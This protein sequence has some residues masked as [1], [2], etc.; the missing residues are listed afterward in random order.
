MFGSRR[1]APATDNQP[2]QSR[3][4]VF[5]SRRAAPATDNQPE[6]SRKRVFRICAVTIAVLTSCQPEVASPTAAR[7]VL[8]EVMTDNDAAWIDEAGEVGDYIEIANLSDR[9]VELGDYALQ[10]ESGQ[11]FPLPH[12]QLA[13]GGFVVV[14]A[15]DDEDQG[16]LHAPWKLSS[17]GERL[18]LI[19]QASGEVLDHVDVPALG[20]N[21]TFSRFP[22]G[23][24]EFRVCRYASPERDNGESCSPPAPL[25]LP[26]DSSWA[27]YD[28]PE[29]WPRSQGS[30]L[31]SELALHP[32]RFIEVLNVGSEPIALADYSLRLAT[33]GPGMPWPTST[34]GAELVWP[35][36]E[37]LAPGARVVVSVSL[38][39]AS[40]IES[41]PAFE[42]VAT[43]FAADGSVADRVDFMRWPEGAVLSRWPET[44]S[45]F[46]FCATPSPGQANDTACD[47]LPSR[48][49]GDRLRHLYTPGD[50]AALAEGETNLGL[51]GVK[52]IVDTA[53]GDAVHLLSTRA[54][55]LHYTFIRE[56]IDHLARL[57]RCDA[58]QNQLFYDG[59][60]DFSD[61]EYAQ[62][63]SRRYLL[64]TLDRYSGSDL[65][66]FDFAL[67]DQIIAPQMKHA[68]FTA[69]KNLDAEPADAW[70]MHPVEPRQVVELRKVE[71]EVP[72]VGENAPFRNLKYQ[73]LTE[74]VAFGTL[75]YLPA[76]ELETA[77]L[78]QDVIVVTD[79]VPNDLPFVSG[80]ITEA[81]QTPLAHVNVLSQ[82]RGT[83]NMAL[84]QART[85]ERIARLIDEL[86]RLEVSSA[87]FTLRK[88][89]AE[90]VDA[91]LQMRAPAGPRVAPRLDA[92][93]RGMVDLATRGLADLPAIGAKAA[94]LAELGHVIA[95]GANCYGPI[96]V[97]DRSF[98]IPV[99]YYLEH[100]ERSGAR[101]ELEAVMQD[102]EFRVDLRARDA[103]LAQVRQKILDAPVD[104]DLMRELEAAILQRWG[105][106]RLRFR[107]SSNTEDLSGFNGA[108]LYESIPA[109]IGDSERPI[110]GA[111]RQVWA[112]LWLTR[113]YDER[114]Y[115]RI[116]Q[117]QVAMGVLVHPSFKSERA[118][119]IAVSRDVLDPTRADIHYLNAQ[120]GEAS[121]ANPAPGVTTEQLIHHWRAV[122]S[123]PVIEY[124]AKSS[125]T[126]GQDVLTLN[127]V[128]K[129]SCR[130]AAVHNYFQAKL[131]P[132]YQN[133]WF[134]M[135]VEIKLV[136]PSREVVFKQARPY[137][138]GRTMRPADCREF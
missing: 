89:S 111:L 34:D 27:K 101:A 12:G 8:N 124:Q 85:D 77:S 48:D 36:P 54:W 31:I 104:A 75:R 43:L 120:Q 39:A 95:T 61:R 9:A 37:L 97:P 38:D 22:S 96:P 86:V 72:V 82:N 128:L 53:M 6:Q 29:G 91:F 81:F 14:F 65:R 126:R 110:D 35:E 136:G 135:D 133:R 131:D 3:K 47:P 83:P 44:S 52:V 118:N 79:A 76:V 90:E 18:Q 134:A 40:A 24:G 66:T 109:E 117:S 71:G 15:D 100:F 46:R 64:A 105:R 62:V 16:I 116:D 63:E 58:A 138:F 60:A 94:Q 87:G 122:P 108:G 13:A 30:L 11:L 125:L 10:P 119:V 21:E 98:A 33:T 130:L 67:G 50:Y 84:R 107:S 123:A 88:A 114:E 80:L 137:T 42:G 26:D 32:A 49:V 93:V 132:Q 19:A 45:R 112:S 1:A 115:G 59:W 4:R 41:D 5:G 25:E 17:K 70:S 20:V 69:M 51:Q 127:D 106:V 74:G 68:F 92:S 57:D 113:A 129:I 2:E 103:A 99:S 121:V 102:P 28:W 78:G 7:L 56:Q 73:P 55:A 23:D